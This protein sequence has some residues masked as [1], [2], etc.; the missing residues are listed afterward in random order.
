[1]PG[2][3]AILFWYEWD[4]SG[5]ENQ[6]RRA[7]ALDPNSADAHYT[8]AHLLS[9]TGRHA[10]ALIEMKL[11]RELDPINLRIAA[12]EAQFLLHAGQI[13]EALDKLRKTVELSPQ[14]WLGHLFLSSIYIEKGM[15]TEA[16]AEADIA[17]ETSGASNHPAAFKGFALAKA[18]KN[19]EAQLVLNELSRQ[20]NERFVPPY[21]FALIYNG[22]GETEK[23]ISWLEHGFVQRDSKMVFLKVEPKWDNLRS[24]PR[25][26]NLLRRMHLE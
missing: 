16:V 18:G 10:E 11:A 12:L 2:L 7:I 25:F 24:D 4:W 21:Y 5:S 3:G 22:L 19:T 17:K 20:S 23:A 9:N 8:Y 13:D 15:Y 1:L 6:C 26:I 14:F